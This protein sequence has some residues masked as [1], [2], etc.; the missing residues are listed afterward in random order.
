MPKYEDGPL[1]ALAEDRLEDWLRKMDPDVDE[2]PSKEFFEEYKPAELFREGIDNRLRE[3]GYAGSQ[4][5]PKEKVAFLRAQF[6]KNKVA[7][8]SNATLKNWLTR[9]AAPQNNQSG[10]ENVFRLCFALEMDAAQTAKFMLKSYLCRPFNY[11]NTEEA[12]YFYCLSNGKS[13]AEAQRIIGL[14]ERVGHAVPEEDVYTKQIGEKIAA[15]RR[16]SDLIDYLAAYTYPKERWHYSARQRIQRLLES[17]KKFARHDRWNNPTDWAVGV[18]VNEPEVTSNDRLLDIIYNFKATDI[19][20]DAK[21]K[22]VVSVRKD[23]D[24]P[25]ALQ[26]NWVGKQ[27]LYRVMDGENVSD[28][29]YRKTLMILFFYNFYADYY[30]AERLWYGEKEIDCRSVYGE[31]EEGLDELLE[32]CG[33]VQSYKRN[34]FDWLILSCAA[35]PDPIGRF[36]DLIDN[37]RKED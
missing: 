25:E 11:K 20:S 9:D 13:Y 17:C 15:I 24:L 4:E 28:E 26:K 14:V 37:Y 7:P 3:L 29:V 36:R 30:T 6:E 27:T 32:S 23:Y 10:R 35:A 12:V 19:V 33:Y 16:E 31:F 1:T 21:G 22:R 5:N 18:Y 2:L 34:P 8:V